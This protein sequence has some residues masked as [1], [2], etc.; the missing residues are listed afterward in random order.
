M[1][2]AV[3]NSVNTSSFTAHASFYTKS[4][5]LKEILKSPC[6]LFKV[7]I[8]NEQ[9]KTIADTILNGLFN[10]AIYSKEKY[11]K[12]LKEIPKKFPPDFKD[13]INHLLGNGYKISNI[14]KINKKNGDY[15]ITVNKKINPHLDSAIILKNSKDNSLIVITRNENISNDLP[16]DDL[17]LRL[18]NKPKNTFK[19]M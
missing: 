1:I 15:I 2:P 19:I 16:Y 10:S 6:D 17:Y 13:S 12:F 4:H 7:N 11:F 5:V 8:S 3:G 14:L 9:S 18:T